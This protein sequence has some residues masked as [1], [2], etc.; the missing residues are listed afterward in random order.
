MPHMLSL[1]ATHDFHGFVPGIN[2]MIKGG[3][4]DADGVVQPSLD[5]KIRRGKQAI[6]ALGKYRVLKSEVG[7][8][9][10]AAQEEELVR[11]EKTIK[12][13]MPYFGYGYIKNAHETVP[14]IPL[15][16]YAFRVMVGLGC[17]FI[18]FFAVTLLLVYKKDITKGKWWMWLA[19]ILLPLGYV[20]SE[21]GWLVAEFGRQPWTIQDMMPTWIGV[22]DL[23][24]DSVMLTFFIFLVL[25][26]ALLIVEI[27]ILCKQIKRGPEYSKSNP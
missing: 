27:N 13:N 18:L 7:S 9:P 3:Y 16:F 11:Y 4:A 5:E 24:S 20:A 21:S 26:T 12:A 6:D 1:M 10:T 19:I 15:C 14:F 22:S 17:L 25:F 2:D 23:S 8:K